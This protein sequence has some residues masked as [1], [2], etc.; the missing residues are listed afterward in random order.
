MRWLG[1]IILIRVSVPL[2]HQL[3]EDVRPFPHHWANEVLVHVIVPH[4]DNNMDLA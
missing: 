2:F 1:N 4:C 3:V